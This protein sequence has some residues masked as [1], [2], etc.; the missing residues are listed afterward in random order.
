MGASEL[1]KLIMLLH[2]EIFFLDPVPTIIFLKK[3]DFLE[4]NWIFSKIFIFSKFSFFFKKNQI[5]K[6]NKNIKIL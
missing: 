5:F 4:K 6:K 1:K 2:D 3:C